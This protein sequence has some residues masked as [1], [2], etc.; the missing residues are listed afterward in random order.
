VAEVAEELVEPVHGRQVLVAIAEVVLAELARGIAEGL[1]QLGDGGIL[2][3]H[4]RRRAGQ[5]DLAQAG[6]E[7]ALSHDERPRARPC[8][9]ARRSSR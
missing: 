2:R 5:P 3:A 7:H 8:S 4:A 6:S 9:S 1:E